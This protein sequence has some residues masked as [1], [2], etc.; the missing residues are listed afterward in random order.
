MANE[1]ITP[2]A[3]VAG[4]AGVVDSRTQRV[5]HPTDDPVVS[6]IGTTLDAVVGDN[7]TPAASATAASGISLWKRIVNLLIAVLAKLPGLGTAGASSA[8]V[9]SVQGI[10][11]GTNLPV[12][13]GTAASLNCTEASGAAIA[14]DTN[15]LTAAPVAKT[16]TTIGVDRLIAVTNTAFRL[17]EAETFARKVYLC[18]QRVAAANAVV[19]N[20]GTSAVHP[21]T[22]PQITLAPGDIFV[23]DPGPGCKVDLYT[24]YINGTA[25]DGVQGWYIPV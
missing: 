2:A 7:T 8:N 24:T 9:I 3:G 22:S 15:E 21:T 25:A 13:Q 17:A 12:S 11:S 18:A 16:I 6:G 1:T 23:L 20:L 10:A 5:V 4:G 14:A 19:I